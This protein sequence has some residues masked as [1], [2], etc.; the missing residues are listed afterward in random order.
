MK[1]LRGFG[2]GAWRAQAGEEREGSAQPEAEGVEGAKEKLPA[3]A[4]WLLM[5]R[6][7]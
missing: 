3:A 1:P 4:L 7:F 5:A 6:S 2:E